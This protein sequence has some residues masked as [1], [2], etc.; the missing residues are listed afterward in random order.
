LLDYYFKENKK[1]INTIVT[2]QNDQTSISSHFFNGKPQF[3]IFLIVVISILLLYIPKAVFASPAPSEAEIE[4]YKKDGTLKKRMD[5]IKNNIEN[6]KVD[7]FLIYN[8]NRKMK[9]LNMDFNS[10]AIQ[11]TTSL[12]PKWSG[13]MPSSG[14]VS[15]VTLLIDFPDY[16]YEGTETIYDIRSRMFGSGNRGNY[17]YESLSEYYKRSSYG[18]LNI[19][20]KVL[21]WYRA[22]NNMDYY[23]KLGAEGRQALIKEAMDYH[24][25]QGVNFAE[26]DGNNDGKIDAVYVKWGGPIKG[27]GS[28]WWPYTASWQ[29]AAFTIDGKTMPRYVWSSC[30]NESGNSNIDIHE[31]GHLLGLPDHYDYDFWGKVGPSGGTGKVTMMDSS[32]GDHDAFSKILLGWIEPKIV[33]EETQSITLTPSE[34]TPTAVIVMTNTN[35]NIFSE[36]FVIEYK[37]MDRNNKSLES[38]LSP[39]LYI[40]HVDATLDSTGYTF[41]YNNSDT[42]HKFIRLMEADGLE[43]IEQGTGLADSDDAYKTGETFGVNTYPASD[44]YSGKY[45]GLQIN[46]IINNIG[47]MTATFGF[48]SDNIAPKITSLNPMNGAVN[49]LIDGQ[50]M[51]TYD[52]SVYLGTNPEDISIINSTTSENMEFTKRILGNKLILKPKLN[53]EYNSTFRVSLRAGAIRDSAGNAAAQFLFVFSTGK[54]A[55]NIEWTKTYGI[56]GV[57]EEAVDIQN[58]KEGGYIAVADRNGRETTQP[59][60]IKMDAKGSIVWEKPISEKDNY[61]RTVKETKDSG[62]II[63]GYRNNLKDNISYYYPALI[64]T[65]SKGNILWSKCYNELDPYSSFYSIIENSEDGYTAVTGNTLVILDKYGGIINTINFGRTLI[66][67]LIE[68]SDGYITGGWRAFYNEE[69]GSFIGTYSIISKVSKDGTVLWEKTLN[70]DVSSIAEDIDDTK[71]GGLILAGFRYN[72]ENDVSLW[73]AKSDD[74]GNI[75]WEKTLD[76]HMATTIS[77]EQTEDN[78]FIIETGRCEKGVNDGIVNKRYISVI[79]TDDTG[80]RLWEKSIDGSGGWHADPAKSCL[81]ASDDG[82]I[83]FGSHSPNN[84]GSDLYII[85]IKKESLLGDLNEDGMIDIKDIGIIGKSYGKKSTNTDWN[86]NYDMK[87]D[88]IIDIYDL[89]MLSKKIVP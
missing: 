51:L 74:R 46:N 16:N 73:L 33:S 9:N 77:I 36:Y 27:W 18:K 7:P 53:L 5:Y 80:N 41:L 60:L 23:E 76:G 14:T 13:G 85:K 50:I 55:P 21:N 83:I 65:D 8:F 38:I 6:H 4:Q 37:N 68:V 22:K 29:D 81:M 19:T 35:K 88:N 26:F 15:T 64:K 57:D 71:D 17:P 67:S 87:R 28:F 12:P 75:L 32:E 31:T 89:V 62:F 43:E 20:G 58:T 70:N 34:D 63:S 24:K 42:E 56:D 84:N 47:S 10:L 54:A 78:G 82:Y 2:N 61:S 30:E 39:G 52:T 45:T 79:K 44:G 49:Q 72:T 3:C 40:W 11:S 86:I 69:T 1:M 25:R 48:V 66:K 59:W